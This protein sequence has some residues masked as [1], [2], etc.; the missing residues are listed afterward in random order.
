ME[1]ALK[2][3]DKLTQ[4]EVRMAVAQ[5]LKATHSVDERVRGVASTAIAMDNRVAVVD[6]RVVRVDDR[7]AHV[8]DKVAE[9]IHGAQVIFCRT[10]EMLNLNPSD[11]KETNQVVT[12]TANDVDLMKRS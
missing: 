4:E 9:V 11:G 3:L 6:D 5:N 2:R 7:V 1:D 12:Q 8:D 10:S